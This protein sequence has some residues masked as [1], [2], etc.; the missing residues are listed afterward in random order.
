[1]K[2]KSGR[3]SFLKN[4]GVASAT[5]ALMPTEI[6][7][8]AP[9]NSAAQPEHTLDEETRRKYNETYTEAYLN[10]VAFPIGGMGAGMFCMEGTGAISHVSI[11]NKPDIFNTPEVF[12]AIS[13]KGL[14]NGAKVLEGPVPD[15]KKFGQR[16]AGNGSGGMTTGL[17][18]FQHSVF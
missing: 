4:I 16:D 18:H 2:P 15:W 3:R 13:I 5:A 10:R 17:P 9:E 7:N 8:A 11:R 6:L 1:M 14:K 12:A